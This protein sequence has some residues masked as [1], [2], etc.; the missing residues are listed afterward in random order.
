MKVRWTF[1]RRTPKPG[2]AWA[3][4]TA[5]RGLRSAWIVPL[6]G[7]ATEGEPRTCQREQGKRS[8]ASRTLRQYGRRPL[9][10][11]H[12]LAASYVPV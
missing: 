2:T 9:L 3:G 7:L 8:A 4:A 6:N 11:I 1:T 5:K 12:P 10:W